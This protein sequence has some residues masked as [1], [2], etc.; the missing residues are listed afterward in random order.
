ML[1]AAVVRFQLDAVRGGRKI[2]MVLK[3][4]KMLVGTAVEGLPSET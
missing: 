1:R 3:L 2:G 4:E